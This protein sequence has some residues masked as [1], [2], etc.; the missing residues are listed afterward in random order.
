MNQLKRILQTN[1]HIKLLKSN[2]SFN[3]LLKAKF[4]TQIAYGLSS[5]Y[6]FDTYQF[7]QRLEAEGFNSKQ[8]ETIV[9]A[10][11]EVLNQSIDDLAKEMVTKEEQEKSIYTYKIDFTQLKNEIKMH[12]KKDYELL[13]L[14]NERLLSE[15]EKLRREF[16]DEINKSQAGFRLDMNLEKGRLKDEANNQASKLIDSQAKV[17][18]EIF[19][20]KAQLENI[21]FQILQ[22]MVGTITGTSALIL[23]Y[24]RM[25]K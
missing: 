25:F 16:K 9:N 4:H 7:S 23:A 19:S 15:V 21:K 5:G 14:E 2:S 22:Y 8:A 1:Q 12:E 24:L 17:E 18:Q 20:L 3:N 13:K 11:D 6:H 10:L